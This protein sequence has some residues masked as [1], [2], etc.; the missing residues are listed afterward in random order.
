MEI[1]GWLALAC[2]AAT[3]LLLLYL[4]WLRLRNAQREKLRSEVA[5]TWNPV[6]RAMRRS[7]PVAKPDVDF[8]SAPYF[9]SIWLD[10][11]GHAPPLFKK[12]LLVLAR[13]KHLDTVILR[14]LRT[15]GL[16]II[17]PPNILVATAVRAARYVDSAEIRA[18][19]R[20]VADRDHQALAIQACET[21][22]YHQDSAGFR[23]VLDL[24]FRYPDQ[25]RYLTTRLGI[26]GGGYLVRVLDPFLEKLPHA[27]LEDIVALV[28][29]S[30][31]ADFLPMI[32]RMLGESHSDE[33]VASLLRT[34]AN[35]GTPAQHHLVVP[36][37][38]S[39]VSF[40]RVQAAVAMG[41]VGSKEDLDLL[42]PLLA[43]SDWW[44]R[45][46]T[47]QSC[48]KLLQLDEY[49]VEALISQQ[50]DQYARDIL[51]HVWS[52]M[53]WHTV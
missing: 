44:V 20:Q 2:I 35:I 3:V 52:E 29:K 18:A 42:R 21:L 19:L 43:D 11:I 7:V 37:L 30:D 36:H 48:V 46:R 38:E 13:S 12:D 28:D 14:L 41:K 45:Y 9:L 26:A 31:D 49:S 16:D 51:K 39:N 34:L 53:T 10:Q 50:V 4:V 47:A 33:Q 5:A 32:E 25:D 15:H 1:A 6:F 22:L 24:L 23:L 40:I 27:R 8:L 17:A